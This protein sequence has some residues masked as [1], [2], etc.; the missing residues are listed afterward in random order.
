MRVSAVLRRQVLRAACSADSISHLMPLL[1]AAPA[2]GAVLMLLRPA[3][4]IWSD[5]RA[6][7]LLLPQQHPP[8]RLFSR[9][10]RHLRES[11]CRLFTSP[12]NDGRLP[13]PRYRETHPTRCFAQ[14]YALQYL[15]VV[16][17][18]HFSVGRALSQSQSQGGQQHAPVAFIGPT[19]PS[20]G[21]LVS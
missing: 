8:A 19:A 11:F 2:A 3:V 7:P 17:C 1:C 21:F 6:R 10:P 16:Y 4:S 12:S 14:S 13:W 5:S 18:E 9:Q 15:S 20:A